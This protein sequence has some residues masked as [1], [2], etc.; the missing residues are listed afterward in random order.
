MNGLSRHSQNGFIIFTLK[1]LMALCLVWKTAG[2]K[3]LG[4]RSRN[5]Y[6]PTLFLIL[7]YSQEFYTHIANF[8]W[9]CCR[10]TLDSISILR[11]P[12]I[13][14]SN[15]DLETKPRKYLCMIPAWVILIVPGN[16]L[17]N[18]MHYKFY[19]SLVNF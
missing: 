11:I 8:L 9:T 12:K 19:Y 17:D 3:I 10:R 2:M 6:I 14:C 4:F 16:N 1:F 7:S 18:S 13:Q 5:V 15:P